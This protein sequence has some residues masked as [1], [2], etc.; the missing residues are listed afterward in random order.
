MTTSFLYNIIEAS[1]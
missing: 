1:Y